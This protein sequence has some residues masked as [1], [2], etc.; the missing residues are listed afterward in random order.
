MDALAG[1]LDGPRARGAFVLRS[2]LDPPWALRVED[3]APLTVVAAVRGGAW[4]VPDDAAAV[5]LAEGD[6]AVLRGPDPYV[7]A[8]APATPAQVV[9]GP[10][11]VCRPAAGAPTAAMTGRG[12]RA[13]GNSPDGSTLLLT[14]TY[15]DA[16][17]VG[18]R[19]LRALPA[20]LVVPA[21]DLDDSLVRYLARE[22]G[23]DEPGQDAVLD[24]LLD[25]LLVAVLRTWLT[26]AAAG[27]PG[28]YRA[29]GD[30]LVGPA[31]RLLHAEPEREWTVA[32]LA[33][34]VGASR[35]ALARRFT[36]VVGQAP[37]AYLGS[38]RLALAAD[39]LLEPGSTV[40]A[41]ARRVG[42][43]S[44]SALSSAFVRER[45]VRPGAHRT[46]RP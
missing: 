7:V 33:R 26:R 11:Q 42:Y 43:G 23:R 28:W 27:A 34:E 24:R 6:V 46:R 37:M 17:E 25:V 31:L 16:G 4:L 20:R 18:R 9:I 45:G 2:R 22:A 13:W 10:G 15:P 41:V 5:E 39:L 40:D 19:L 44:G 3:G 32:S 30:P 36:E 8:D 38:W 35:A 21:R 1:L 12:P 14:G 29:S